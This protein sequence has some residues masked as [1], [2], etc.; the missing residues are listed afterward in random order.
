MG[1]QYAS[2]KL[3]SYINNG[4]TLVG[5]AALPMNQWSMVA[6]S[7]DGTNRRIYLNG[8]LDA[9]GTAPPITGDDT[10][11]AIGSVVGP[12]ATFSGRIDEVMIYN[13]ALA[14]SEILDLY[15]AVQGPASPPALLLVRSGGNVII[16]WPST[17]TTGFNLELTPTVAAP[18]SWLTNSTIV[19]DDN[20]N[21]SVTIPATTGNKFFRLRKP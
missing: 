1:L 5:N 3:E 21:K 16:S 17:G 12:N 8:V 14:T 15:N 11:S 9:T 10:G 18:A 6:L 7:Y 13:R 4:N 20:T 19:A 2:G